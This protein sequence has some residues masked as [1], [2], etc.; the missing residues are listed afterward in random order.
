M[1]VVQWLR[2]SLSERLNRVGVSRRTPRLMTEADPVTETFFFFF[3][4][5]KIPDV[6]QSPETQRFWVAVRPF[7]YSEIANR[8]GKWIWR[9][10]VLPEFCHLK[11][12]ASVRQEKW[13][14]FPCRTLR[15][16]GDGQSLKDPS[17]SYCSTQSAEPIRICINLISSSLCFLLWMI[18]PY[19]SETLFHVVSLLM[20][21]QV[22]VTKNGCMTVR[23]DLKF[24]M[25]R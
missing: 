18:S 7:C 13:W 8:S 21:C 11:P 23:F 12:I 16:P 24:Q 17:Y 6:G 1:W 20:R 10:A 14:R 9:T 2:L 22:L 4:V 15:I 5:F 25:T 19:S 3:F